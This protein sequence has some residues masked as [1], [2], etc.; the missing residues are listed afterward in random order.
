[1]VLLESL[2]TIDGGRT[3]DHFRYSIAKQD[4]AT[5]G[6]SRRL[7]SALLQ[8]ITV[9]HQVHYLWHLSREQGEDAPSVAELHR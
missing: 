5:E 9:E 1:M 8:I 2:L 7:G 4:E 6:S 3:S